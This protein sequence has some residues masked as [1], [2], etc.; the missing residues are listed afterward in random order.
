MGSA[1]SCPV[2]PGLYEQFLLFGDSITEFSE[3]QDVGFGFA[4]ALRYA[5]I[6]RLE[7]VNRGLS[8]YNT[9]MALKVIDRV[10]PKPCEARVRLMTIFFGA[11]D[12]CFPTERSNQCVPLPD[13]K[14]NLIKIV[15]H[16]AVTAHA[17]RIVL[18]TPPPIDERTQQAVDLTKGFALRRSAENTRRYAEAVCEVGKEL[19]LPVLDLWSIFMLQAGW[20]PE[21]EKPLPGS[22]D[23]APNEE[24]ARLLID[25]LHLT[26]AGY[27]LM[28]D[29]FNVVLAQAY[30]TE[31][32]TRL[33]YILPRWDDE[34]AWSNFPS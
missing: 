22:L 7:V 3:K 14:A 1:F 5:Y 19:G 11:N 25:G 28:Y 16:P 27:Q 8:G 15:R 30:P 6:R 13:F 23:E 20:K 17:S 26:P 31:V 2:S 33:P 24:L 12:S 18:I 32:P 29:Q 4:P 21:A 9:A 34:G 10:I